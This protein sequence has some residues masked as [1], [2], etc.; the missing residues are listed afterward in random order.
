MT[1]FLFQILHGIELHLF[2]HLIEVF[3]QIGVAGDAEV[4]A[5]VE[6]KLLVD[7]IAENVFF[8]VGVE[9]VGIF[10]VLLFHF[11]PKLIL[12]ALKLRLRDDLVVDAGNDFFDDCPE[13]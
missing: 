6:E 10:G 12:A 7:E 2:A 11:V 5:F 1:R 3:D 8:T 9:L 13:D 4:L